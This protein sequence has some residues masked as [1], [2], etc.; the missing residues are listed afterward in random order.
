MHEYSIVRALLEQVETEADKHEAVEVSRIQIRVGELA[1]VDPQLLQTAWNLFREGT[2]CA[3]ASLDI[4]AEPVRWSC[5]R[6]QAV[7]ETGQTLRCAAC[8]V[9]AHLAAG[10]A[11]ILERIEMEV[12]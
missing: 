6:C 4:V 10:D 9:P 8:E 2:R 11:L 12:E 5:P 3:G 1:G 7:I